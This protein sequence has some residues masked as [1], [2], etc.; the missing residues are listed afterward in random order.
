MA[1]ACSPNTSATTTLAP[2]WAKR[3]ASAS[4]MPCAAPVTIATLSSRRMV[5]SSFKFKTD[6]AWYK[7]GKHSNEELAPGGPDANDKND[8]TAPGKRLMSLTDHEVK[9][10]QTVIAPAGLTVEVDATFKKGLTVEVA[11]TSNVK[12]SG[13]E[14]ET[15][16][17]TV[18]I[19]RRSRHDAHPTGLALYV[20]GA[21][22]VGRTRGDLGDEG[23]GLVEFRDFVSVCG[24]GFGINSSGGTIYAAGSRQNQSLYVR[25]KGTGTVKVKQED[26]KQIGPPGANFV[27]GWKNANAAFFKDGLGIVHFRGLVF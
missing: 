18:D 22:P 20:T 15:K 7:D 25:A 13:G 12:F 11:A 26:W 9:Q 3:R 14:D 16:V 4:P 17:N 1:S 19:M 24:V 10:G 21:W 8:K 5:S 27:N 2:S 6:F 23:F